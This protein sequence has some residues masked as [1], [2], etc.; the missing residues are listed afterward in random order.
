MAAKLRL[1]HL[2]KEVGAFVFLAFRASS[3]QDGPLAEALESWRAEP[4]S[5]YQ[6]LQKPISAE[7]EERVKQ[8]AQICVRMGIERC[9]SNALHSVHSLYSLIFTAIYVP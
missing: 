2:T 1:A 9:G 6:A 4:K 7:N 8:Q 5:T 3:G